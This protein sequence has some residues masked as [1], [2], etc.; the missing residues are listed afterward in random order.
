MFKDADINLICRQCSRQFV[1]SKAE[2]EFYELKDF[3]SPSRCQECRSAKQNEPYRFICSQCGT[4]LEKEDFVYCTTCLASVQLEVEQKAKKGQEAV[5]AART[6]LLAAESEKAELAESLRRKEQLV[7]ELELKLN[8]LGQE[9]E[10]AV[11]FHTALEWLQPTL[12]AIA[13]RVEDLEH[14]QGVINEKMLQTIRAMSEKYA[15]VSLWEL[16]KRSLG[17]NLKQDA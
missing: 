13:E 10:K 14:T 16:I 7:A 15:N 3:T 6:K 11:Q 1:F 12:D 8:N 2:Q 4:G 5:S 9:L 17:Q